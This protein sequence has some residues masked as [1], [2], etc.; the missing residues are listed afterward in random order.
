MTEFI[1][2]ATKFDS[3][4]GE[5]NWQDLPLADRVAIARYEL[6]GSPEELNIEDYVM[7]TKLRR[8]QF[9][10]LRTV[11]IRTALA[12]EDLLGIRFGID[13]KSKYSLILPYIKDT[14]LG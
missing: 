10:G 4:K 1:S 7:A 3:Y 2:W 12:L 14:S 8:L 5:L 11:I 13:E 9:E 6:D